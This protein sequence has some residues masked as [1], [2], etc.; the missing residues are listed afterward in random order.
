MLSMRLSVRALFRAGVLS[1][2]LSACQESATTDSS[3]ENLPTAYPAVLSGLSKSGMPD[4]VFWRCAKLGGQGAVSRDTAAK[5]LTVIVPLG[6]SQI[7][8][9]TVWLSLWTSGLLIGKVPYQLTNGALHC[10]P[11]AKTK[12]SVALSLLAARDSAGALALSPT[13][14]ELYA[15]RLLNED[16]HFLGFPSNAPT[17]ISLDS[18]Y[19]AG[20]LHAASLHMPISVLAQRLGLDSVATLTRRAAL[21]V[22]RPTFSLPGGRYWKAQ[23]VVLACSTEVAEIHYTLDGSL[24]TVASARFQGWVAVTKSATLKAVAMKAGRI[25]SPIDSVRYQIDT[26]AP[27]DTVPPLLRRG[28]PTR[29]TLVPCETRNLYLAWEVSDDSALAWVKLSGEPLVSA[30]GLYGKNVSLATGMNVFVLSASDRHGNLVY[31]TLRVT[32]DTDEVGPQL[33]WT[34]PQADIS[35]DG[36]TASFLVKVEAKD[37]SGVDSVWIDGVRAD[38]SQGVWSRLVRLPATGKPTAIHALAWDRYG[39]RA[40]S[41]RRITRPFFNVAPTLAL[42]VRSVSGWEGEPIALGTAVVKDQE[43]SPGHLTVKLWADDSVLVPADSIKVSGLDTLRTLTVKTRFGHWGETMLHVRLTDSSGGMVQDSLKL[44]IAAINHAPM[45]SLKQTSVRATTW[46]GM[47]TFPL[48]NVLWD[49]ASAT[50]GGRVDLRLANAVDT[51]LVKALHVDSLGILHVTAKVDTTAVLTF[52]IRAHD[53]GGMARGGVDTSAWM[54]V[55]LQLVDTL[56]DG[57]GHSIRA[58]TMP[59]G[60][61]WMMSDLLGAYSW[62]QAL[63]LPGSCDSSSDDVCSITT[64]QLGVCPAGWRL[65]DASEWLGLVSAAAAGGTNKDGTHHL[66]SKTWRDSLCGAG[67]SGENGDD[68]FGFSLKGQRQVSGPGA[69]GASGFWATFNAI[70]SREASAFYVGWYTSKIITNEKAVPVHV[71]CVR[72]P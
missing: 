32:R 25:A 72:D 38:S 30:S 2:A 51:A 44:S 59:D 69:C 49:D 8:S 60:K 20:I 13:L 45:L 14:A 22:A 39:N 7:G 53:E 3:Q 56:E 21:T 9:D 64:A 5:S 50:Q 67:T 29:D 33:T 4:S 40:D 11:A 15:Q 28:T 63:R 61:V 31:D 16:P 17:G 68:L 19:A 66:L 48:A 36:V 26:A 71:R 57:D 24:P 52:L 55:T 6:A 35:V 37:R 65:P 42:S 1:F 12:D 43:T 27:V 46:K 23:Q 34:S 62:S 58:G 54:G 18:V 10:L 70:S 41:V 47:Q